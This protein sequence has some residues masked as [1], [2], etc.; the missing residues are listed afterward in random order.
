MKEVK[1]GQYRKTVLENGIRVV[2]EYMPTVKSLALGFWFYVGS[3]DE[4]DDLAG[5]SHYLEH[6]NFKG[7]PK[8]SPVAIARTIEGKGGHINAF[9]GREMTCFYVR[10][11]DEQLSTA[12][13]LLADITQ[14][15]HFPSEEVEREKG[16]ILEEIK[17]IEDTPDEW[18]FDHFYQ[19]IYPNHPL[20]RPI[21]GY[22]STLQRIS[23]HQ[24]IEYRD[25]HYSASNLVVAA[26]GSLN[27]DQL[28]HIVEK[29]FKR[30][31]FLNLKRTPPDLLKNGAHNHKV[32]TQTQQTHI[33][34]GVHTFPYQDPRKFPLLVLNTYLG[35]GMSS[36]LFQVVR[37]KY[38]L[39]YSVYSFLEFFSD[40]GV[41][42]IYAGTEPAKSSRALGLILKE[43]EKITLKPFT[44]RQLRYY[45]DQLKGGLLLSL[46]SPSARMNRLGK[47]EL[48]TGQWFS[49]DD[50]VSRIEQVQPEDI[51][52]LAQEL[53]QN[54]TRF[55]T[56]LV[57]RKEM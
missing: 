20:G 15:S 10:V 29:K 11:I 33:V 3:R 17:N 21:I 23:R 1:H 26:A 14:A 25:T 8:R 22:R 42:G 57:P 16:V 6:M 51:Q 49:L 19:Q 9:T 36:R 45:K 32:E 24:L 27:H 12:V 37:E 47:M 13:D 34:W 53:F 2:T 7:T 50:V 28:V 40:T 39:A 48:Y 30:T 18:V 41:F 35:G 31:S 44:S 52:N 4:P 54:R 55:T 46:E 56:M 43:V 38:G 5:I